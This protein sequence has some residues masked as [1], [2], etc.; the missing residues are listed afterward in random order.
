MQ[1]QELRHIIT[2]LENDLSDHLLDDARA[3]SPS[4][5]RARGQEPPDAQLGQREV[6]DMINS[7]LQTHE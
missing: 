4:P 5:D 3:R 6:M 1:N 7:A 2:Q